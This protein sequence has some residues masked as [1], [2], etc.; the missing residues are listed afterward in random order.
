[1]AIPLCLLVFTISR[2][3]SVFFLFQ[4]QFRESDTL[5]LVE[6]DMF[7]CAQFT[8]DDGWY[9]ARIVESSSLGDTSKV[10]VIYVDFGNHE[11]LPVSRLRMLRKE[12]AELPMMSVLCAL[13]GVTPPSVVRY[14]LL[15]VH[16]S[17]FLCG[18]VTRRWMCFQS[19]KKTRHRTESM[20]LANVKINKMATL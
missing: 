12:H 2:L 9:R 19:G 7:C 3:A 14:R 6:K 20:Q 10:H 11:T 16:L 18:G 8:E 15:N 1:M 17:S 13:D 4:D 5:P